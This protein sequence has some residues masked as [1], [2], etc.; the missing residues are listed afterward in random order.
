MRKYTVIIKKTNELIDEELKTLIKL[1][2]Q[3]WPYDELEQIKWF[4]NNIKLNDH[5][6]MIYKSNGG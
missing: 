5:H 6:I 2:Q 1:K 3:Y 4:N